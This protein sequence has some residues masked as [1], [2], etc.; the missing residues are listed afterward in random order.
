MSFSIFAITIL[1]YLAGFV[2]MKL[3]EFQREKLNDTEILALRAAAAGNKIA[4]Q[5]VELKSEEKFS[6]REYAALRCRVDAIVSKGANPIKPDQLS[7]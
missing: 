3:I 5:L 6:P 4:E 7:D 1:M 2:Y